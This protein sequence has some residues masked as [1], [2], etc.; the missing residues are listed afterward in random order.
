[1]N[2]QF[3][4]T[5]PRRS[6]MSIVPFPIL[7]SG[8]KIFL[9]LVFWFFV[10]FLLTSCSIERIAIKSSTTILK[11]TVLAI[12]EEEDPVIAEK[13]IAS[14]LKLLE[15]MIKSDPGNQELLLLASR[16]FCSYAFSFIEDYDKEKAKIFYKRGLKY[17]LL[18]LT[19][20]KSFAGALKKGGEALQKELNKTGNQN[21]PSL[22]WTAYCWGNLINL[23]RNTP[24]ALMALPKVEKM[25]NRVLHLNGNYYFGGAYLFFGVLYGSLPPMFGGK[26]EQSKYHFEKAIE[27]TQGKFLMAFV[28]YAKSYA[29]QTQEKALFKKLL[30]QV[31]NS[32]QNILPSQRLANNLAKIKAKDLLEDI[33][34]YF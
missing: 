27:I 7:R 21:V 6:K 8:K 18:I 16:G 9:A 26:P 5:K 19:A 4:A 17:G 3:L 22:F 33:S 32:P 12:N 28:Q 13:A 25:M 31:I 1:M 24:E 20:N 30:N 34:E 11:N 15:G 14:Q 23:S 2:N 10:A 29:I